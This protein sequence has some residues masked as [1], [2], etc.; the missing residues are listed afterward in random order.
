MRSEKLYEAFSY[1]DDL[2]LDIAETF[3]KASA[4]T[5][6]EHYHFS[7]KRTLTL[8]LAAIICIS[9]LTVTA[10][11]SG[12]IGGLFNLLKEKLPQD[13]ALFGAAAQAN[14]DAV[15]EII[16]IPQ[17][18]LSQFVLLEEYFDGETILIGYDVNIDLPDPAVGIEPAPELMT[19]IKDGT[20][21][22]EISW[23]GDEPW[24]AVPATENAVRYH[25][26]ADAAEM[27]RML[28]G[29]LSNE[30]Y[31]KAWDILLRH[32]YVCIAVRDAWIGD[33]LLINGVD[34]VEAYLESNAYADRTEYTTELGYCIR[35][36]PLPEDIRDKDHVTVTLNIKS[37]VS[38]WYL[39]LNGEGRIYYDDSSITTDPVSFEIERIQ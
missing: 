28:K 27:D 21:M 15:P 11:A 37:S 13:E 24:L 35:L 22:T 2:Y 29:T 16:Q 10:L 30:N 31:Q 14:I 20:K 33:H 23:Q 34:T 3:P 12:W 8:L 1:I 26:P 9:L 17:L 25:L 39:S 36:E 6:E 19:N 7:A 38:Y 4:H 18:D 5:D 32:G